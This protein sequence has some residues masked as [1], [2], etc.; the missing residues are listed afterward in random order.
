MYSNTFYIAKFLLY[1]SY[2]ITNTCAFLAVVGFLEVL[3]SDFYKYPCHMETFSALFQN[4]MNSPIL[5]K[6]MDLVLCMYCY[7]K[8]LT[9]TFGNR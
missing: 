1:S 2:F 5:T 3:N 8:L 7:S 9:C 6:F 4:F